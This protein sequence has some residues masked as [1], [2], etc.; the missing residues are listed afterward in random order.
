MKKLYILFFTFIT[1]L[2]VIILIVNREAIP[3]ITYFPLDQSLSFDKAKTSIQGFPTKK[4]HVYDIQ[5]RGSSSSDQPYYLRQDV[6]LLFKNGFLKDVI[7][8]WESDATEIFWETTFL[9]VDDA[10]YESISFHHGEIHLKEEITSAQ[11][12]ST[13]YLYINLNGSK[14]LQF[15]QPTSAAEH[16]F[17]YKTDQ[18]INKT[19][20]NHWQKLINFFNIQ[21]DQYNMFPFTHLYEYNNQALPH[22]SKV[23][24]QKV[25][26]Q[27]WEGFYKNYLTETINFNIKNYMP[28]ILVDHSVTHII[29]LYELNGQFKQLIQRI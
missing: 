1:S 27:L 4:E 9:N 12:M 7:N 29:I 11:T 21:T 6:S 18:S 28:L 2:T 24:T 26:G 25:I 14:P 19:L 17:K 20:E 10:L 13:D 23:E 15:K 22:L 8:Q 5:W 3:I 16:N